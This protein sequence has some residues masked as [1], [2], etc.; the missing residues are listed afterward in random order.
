MAKQKLPSILMG[1]PW[2]I[3]LDAAMPD[4]TPVDFG[5]TKGYLFLASKTD[6]VRLKW[7]P[8]EGGNDGA[9]ETIEG[10]STLA[11][12]LPAEFTRDT[13][14]FPITEAT[15]YEVTFLVGDLTGSDGFGDYIDTIKVHPLR[16]GLPV[17]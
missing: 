9:H 16:D 3:L 13:D 15:D 17:S 2:A 10:V 1:R 14:N 4:G 12:R 7:E 6:R 11:F 5:T 8:G